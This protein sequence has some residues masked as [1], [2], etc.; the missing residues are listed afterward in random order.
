M[1]D[2]CGPKLSEFIEFGHRLRRQGDAVGSMESAARSIIRL[3]FR[4]LV[5]D[6]KRPACVL[7]RL[8]LTQPL[9]SLPEPL[10]R[11]AQ[12]RLQEPS[13]TD[14]PQIPCLTLLA[15]K[16]IEPTWNDR[17]DSVAH[18]VIPLPHAGVL[19]KAPMIARLIEQLGLDSDVLFQPHRHRI[20]ELEPQS[21]HVFHVE[22]ALDSLF[23]P[24]QEG[25]VRPYGVR[26]VLGFG[27]L[28][29][30]T[31]L[32][33]VLLF[34]R[35]PISTQTA[36]LFRPLALGAK[37][38]LLPF[39]QGPIFDG[40]AAPRRGPIDLV[41]RLAGLETL[42]R[43]HEAVSLEQA[44]DLENLSAELRR[45][46]VLSDHSNDAQY[47]INRDAQIIYANTTACQ[48]LGYTEAELT[49]LTVPEIDPN[50]DLT[51]YQA[52]FDAA[53]T[54]KLAPFETAHRCKDGSILPVEIVV[55]GIPY[56]GQSYILAVVR[57]ITERKRAEEA[58]DAV[59]RLYRQ[60]TEGTLDAIV[61]ADSEARIQLFNPAAQRMFGLTETEVLGELVTR[62]MPEELRP[63]HA[64]AVRRYVQTRIPK[65]VGKTVELTGQRSNGERFPIE[66]A[67]SSIELPEGLILLASMRDLTERQK[68]QARVHQSEKLASVGLLAAGVAHEINNPLA[69]VGSNLSVIE[70]YVLGLLRIVDATEPLHALL[71]DRPELLSPL[72]SLAEEVDLPYIRENLETIVKSTRQGVRRVAD[73]VQHLRGFAR[74][75][76]VAVEW[77]EPAEIVGTS[78]E[79]VARRLADKGIEVVREHAPCPPVYCTV[80]QI[81][82][83]VLNLL[84]NAEHA[85]ETAR[86]SGGR[87]TIRTRAE[88]PM[89]VIEVEDNGV[90][91]PA[92]TLGRIFDPFFTSKPVGQGTGLGLA[93][94][95]QI[96]CDHCGRI[97]VA[98][99][100]GLGTTF[101]VL[102][103]FAG[104]G[105]P[106]S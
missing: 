89:A 9:G 17:R 62:L 43:V 47:F 25:F 28:L 19:E 106:R 23:V 4:E 100:P 51:R 1:L 94:S 8:F 65:I 50:Y 74:P 58:R 14:S 24:A 99:T 59:N 90:G 84:V 57:D 67:L 81:H 78:L 54:T 48:R 26:S 33:A 34:C 87:I 55:T 95:H 88:P 38:A 56:L 44:R 73:I 11:L 18:E 85:I 68:M 29:P 71:S 75:D 3:F 32:F 79:M 61:V 30:G 6:R 15:T 12:S 20:A 35:V 96:I 7:A 16:G 63:T 5:D 80:A 97:E 82:Q 31:S 37:L 101:R 93:I 10:Q 53:Q 13:A 46:K 92:Q 64:G 83:V 49:A 27:G 42:L 72:E 21:Y 45:F 86:K 102:L 52:A 91:I 104:P 66:L 105:S 22:E 36:A 41:A 76:R 77:A 69:Y 40:G 103:P 39:A 60:L 2:L 98:S 70:R